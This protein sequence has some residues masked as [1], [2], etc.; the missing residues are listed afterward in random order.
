MARLELSQQVSS[1]A[2]PAYG[3]VFISTAGSSSRLRVCTSAGILTAGVA[4]I[5]TAGV[6]DMGA[7]VPFPAR[8][9]GGAVEVCVRARVL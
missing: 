3:S 6:A 5:L 7:F 4:G 8:G 9:E 1:G 2:F